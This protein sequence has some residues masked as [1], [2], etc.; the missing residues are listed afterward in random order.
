MFSPDMASKGP[1]HCPL[2]CTWCVSEPRL[3]ASLEAE[4]AVYSPS[5]VP[6]LVPSGSAIGAKTCWCGGILSRKVMAIPEYNGTICSQLYTLRPMIMLHSDTQ[7]HWTCGSRAAKSSW[8]KGNRGTMYINVPC[9]FS[10]SMSTVARTP[11]QLS[12]QTVS[13]RKV[14]SCSTGRTGTSCACGLTWKS[15]HWPTICGR[16]CRFKAISC[17]LYVEDHI[18][19]RSHVCSQTVT[20]VRATPRLSST[21]SRAGSST[22]GVTEFCIKLFKSSM[23]GS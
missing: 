6:T 10:D 16:T 19:L 12:G 3:D 15:R 4:D 13:R 7:T 5:E 18:S 17:L 21:K 9:Q 11:I 8:T 14:T 1:G 23:V 2:I 22:Y 20:T